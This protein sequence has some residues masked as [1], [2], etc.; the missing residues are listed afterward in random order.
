MQI[1]DD[2]GSQHHAI[3]DIITNTITIALAVTMICT[4]E[5]TSF[6]KFSGAIEESDTSEEEEEEMGC[7]S[8]ISTLLHYIIYH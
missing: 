4:G 2:C 8:L 3:L 7:D 1:I 6:R 5:P